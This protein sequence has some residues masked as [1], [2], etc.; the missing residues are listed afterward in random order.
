MSLKYE[1]ASEQRGDARGVGG[2]MGEGCGCPAHRAR[3][4]VCSQG[5]GVSA[6]VLKM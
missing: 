5:S 6:T 2:E 1:P 4:G 3:G